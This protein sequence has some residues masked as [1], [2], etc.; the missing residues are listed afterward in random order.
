MLDA[1]LFGADPRGFHATNLLLHGASAGILTS[2]LLL[3]GA[4]PWGAALGA[5]AWAVHPLR[6]ESVAWI[7]ERKDT[8]S[9]VFG[10]LAVHAYLARR[11]SCAVGARSPIWWAA[12]WM[13]LSLLCKATFVTLPALLVLLDY[14]P[15]RRM[16]DGVRG[17]FAVVVEKWPLWALSAGFAALAVVAQR[18]Q[19]ALTDFDRLPL[20]Y[21]LPNAIVSYG[22]YLG[23]TLWPLDLAAFYPFPV[24]GWPAWRWLGVGLV[25]AAVTA[26]CW[27]SR[28]RAPSLLVGW[29]WYVVG[30]LPVIGIVQVGGQS[31]A[32]RYTYLPAIGLVLGV[33]GALPSALGS[34]GRH[35]VAAAGV[36]LC[37]GLSVL[38]W[39][40]ATYWQ[41][42]V[43]LMRRTLA[44]TDFNLFAQSSLAHAHLARGDLDAARALYEDVLA[45]RG[46]IAAVHVNLGVIAAAKREH[47]R[48]IRHYED[49]IRIDAGNFEAYN[50]LAAALLE[51]GRARAAIAALERALQLRPA[52]PDALFN[53]GMAQ[54]QSGDVAG[55]AA[56]YEAVLALTP[57]DAEARYRAGALRLSLGDHA[58]A[59]R[60]LRAALA[61]AP[62]HA[63]AADA[64]R[65]TLEGGGAPP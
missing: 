35:R 7:S 58:A 39:R 28:R 44:V 19:A 21:R 60:H 61:L 52:D 15:L 56:T 4:P 16:R 9:L 59:E 8:L 64:L 57:N 48:A 45:A 31:M 23:A 50:N 38:T 43:T 46:D 49:G 47:E 53:L 36:A 32:D 34:A 12:L 42:T 63:Q 29:G 40:Q 14:W 37:V 2:I 54:A 30:L 3:A 18:S 33:V 20:D 22:R 26:L 24:A 6:V 5:L 10:L 17:S 13:A 65:R 27:W 55:A 25:L 62:G 51:T 11:V 1:Q 41:D